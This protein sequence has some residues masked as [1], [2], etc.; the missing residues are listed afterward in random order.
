MLIQDTDSVAKSFASVQEAIRCLP[1]GVGTLQNA[2]TEL[3]CRIQE[4]RDTL[5]HLTTVQDRAD[6]FVADTIEA[7]SAAAQQ[8]HAETEAFY[9]RC[10]WARP[11]EPP[12]EDDRNFVE[13]AFDWACDTVEAVVD[14]ISDGIEAFAEGFR[15]FGHKFV[16]GIR[17]ALQLLKD[18]GNLAI[19]TLRTIG[20]AIKDFVSTGLQMIKDFYLEHA[21]LIRGIV[22]IV[23]GVVMI[24]AAVAV[25]AATFGAG[26]AIIAGV[27]LTGFAV[28]SGA[29]KGMEAQENGGSFFS[30]FAEGF[31]KSSVTNSMS[32]ICTCAGMPGWASAT[33]G[34]AMT[35]STDAAHAYMDDFQIDKEEG[36]E[37]LIDTVSAG[38]TNF[39]T[40]GLSEAINLDGLIADKLPKSISKNLP[41]DFWFKGSP[42]DLGRVISDNIGGFASN[43]VSDHILNPILGEATAIIDALPTID[44]NFSFDFHFD[45]QLSFA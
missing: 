14:T 11:P 45:F 17:D 3:D 5:E 40:E 33:V 41:N 9:N 39:A 4:E 10:P 13:K 1:G 18:I 34:T 6:S 26:A 7:D 27:C 19:D 21:E 36:R 15:E 44:I 12:P 30:G 22:E 35:A 16:E 29:K 20:D 37:I 25:T 31:F 42:G 43:F 8:I 32:V 24:V 23:V 2:V 38:I 28:Y